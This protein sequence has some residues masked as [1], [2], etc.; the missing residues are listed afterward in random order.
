LMRDAAYLSRV[1]VVPLTLKPLT[2]M[3]TRAGPSRVSVV[4]LC[5]S[6]ASSLP[7]TSWGY[8]PTSIDPA[9]RPMTIK[10][11]ALRCFASKI[12]RD[13]SGWGNETS[14]MTDPKSS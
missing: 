4:S 7:G 9:T 1:S 13:Q 8:S 12:R 11:A 5:P 3:I 10:P 14:I 2:L 6:G